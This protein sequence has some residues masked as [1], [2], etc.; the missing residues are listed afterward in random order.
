MMTRNPTETETTMLFTLA[1]S[2]DAFHKPTATWH[3]HKAPHG[4]RAVSRRHALNKGLKIV[5]GWPGYADR[6]NHAD[7]T[8]T[9]NAAIA[10]TL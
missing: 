2:I 6:V 1:L 4:V 5:T 9:A 3:V 10:P 7:W 8:V